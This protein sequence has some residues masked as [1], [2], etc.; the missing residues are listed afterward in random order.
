[1]TQINLENYEP[2]EERINRFY[3]DHPEARIIT[4]LVSMDG[5]PG[6]TRWVVKALVFRD[7]ERERPDATGY[8]FEID[9]AGMT[10]RVAALETGETSAI[11]RALANLG[12]A[13][14]RRVTREEM[15]K[16]KRYEEQAPSPQEFQQMAKQAKTDEELER[17]RNRARSAGAPPAF[18]EGL[19]RG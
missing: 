6:R 13:G 16:V 1:M 17:V 10:Q 5:E 15:A 12:Y 19:T 9:G 4:D 3:K 11:G 7:S 8:A 2:V 14:N 18:V